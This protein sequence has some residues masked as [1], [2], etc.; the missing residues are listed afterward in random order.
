LKSFVQVSPYSRVVF[1]P[2]DVRAVDVTDHG[3]VVVPEPLRE[4]VEPFLDG[5]IR[6]DVAFVLGGASAR[7]CF[8]ERFGACASG[9]CSVDLKV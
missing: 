8:V 1:A 5:V 3:G 2:V 4:T 7:Y 6:A 9:L